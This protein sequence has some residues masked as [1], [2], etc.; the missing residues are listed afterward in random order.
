MTRIALRPTGLPL[1]L[2]FFTLAIDS[3]LVSALQWGLLTRA[4]SRA[5]ALVVFPAFVVQLIG[6]PNRRGRAG[7]G[8]RRSLSR[9]FS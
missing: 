3:V 2:G 8:A 7:M 4:D 1:P 9:L 5:A 6:P